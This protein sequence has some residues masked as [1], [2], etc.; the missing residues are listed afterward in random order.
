LEESILAQLAQTPE[1][2]NHRW[3]AFLECSQ[4]LG[5]EARQIFQDV[6]VD[7]RRIKEVAQQHGRT[8]AGTYMA[9]SRIRRRLMECIDDRLQKGNS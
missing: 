4:G 9:L 1:E 5:S 8:L 3:T 7:R 2:E 6:Y